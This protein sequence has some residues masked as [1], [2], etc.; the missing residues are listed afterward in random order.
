MDADRSAI[1]SARP[2]F[3][4]GGQDRPALASGLLHLAVGDTIE[5]LSTCEAEFGNWGLTGNDRLGH[6]WF[7]RQVLDF[8]KAFKVKLGG[9]TLF[10]GRIVAIEARFP[11]MAPPT[12][13]VRADDRLQDLRMTRR[14]RSFE[15]VTD[16]DLMQ[17]IASDHG[18]QTEID[19]QGPTWPLIVQANESDLA[20]LRRRAL[21]ADADLVIA[22]G[23][24]KAAARAA[25]RQSAPQ[26]THGARLHRFTVSADLAHQRTAITC[27]GW[28]VGSKQA[29][30][31]EAT[32]AAIAGEAGSGES[33]PRLLQQA[34]G[35]RKDLVGHRVPFDG[36][37][38]R[39]EAEAHLRLIARRFV[40]G[41]GEADT[42]PALRAG[43]SVELQGL[44]PLFDG[45]YGVTDV[46]HR[47]DAERGLRTEFGVERAWIGRP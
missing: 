27:A 36:S 9:D 3:E 25:R 8:G 10:D 28:D 15:S 2:G 20:F 23:K 32:S 41:R 40:R 39:S 44:G 16:A 33:G 47:F 19:L 43:G 38:A 4:V 46:L 21:A 31:A 45:R 5:G 11:A 6:L 1:V 22:D 12:L 34:L 24:L 29:V 26:L 30:A 17:R 18:L 14:T 13:A 42:E 35:E 7:D 37:G